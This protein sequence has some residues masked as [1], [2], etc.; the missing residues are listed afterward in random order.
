[1]SV[2]NAVKLLTSEMGGGIISLTDQKF[3]SLQTMFP[4]SK[5]GH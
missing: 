5:L 1:M 2:I 4:E 3:E